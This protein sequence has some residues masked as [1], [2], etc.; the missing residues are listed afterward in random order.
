MVAFYT[1]NVQACNDDRGLKM[2]FFIYK[3]DEQQ[4]LFYFFPSGKISFQRKKV[5]AN[6]VILLDWVYSANIE[7]ATKRPLLANPG[8]SRA[9]GRKK[10]CLG[11]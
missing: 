10:S 9:K 1:A 7:N 8:F 11:T 5:S 3:K 4:F 2:A 6:L